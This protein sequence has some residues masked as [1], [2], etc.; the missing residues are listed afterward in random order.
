MKCS[1]RGLVLHAA[2]QCGSRHE[3][4]VVRIVALLVSLTLLASCVETQRESAQVQLPDVQADHGQSN[5]QPDLKALPGVPRLQG[6]VN[7]HAGVFTEQQ[8]SEIEVRLLAY[9]RD[10][11]HHVALL[12][13]PTL[14][15]EPIEAFSLRVAQSWRL[16]RKDFDNGVLLTV[17]PTDRK[18]RIELGTG[19]RRFVS[20]AAAAE[21]IASTMIPEFR[22]N[23][24][25]GGIEAGLERLLA[26]CRAYKVG[27]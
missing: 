19:M 22:A 27:P 16:G 11:T 5:A 9:E 18:V 7:D 10:T 24:I 23:R 13:V 2:S 3:V 21:I 1:L 12:T 6:R 25:A 17:S 15:G 20:D 8:R 4:T 14:S 26:A